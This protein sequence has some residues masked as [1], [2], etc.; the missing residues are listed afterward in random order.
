MDNQTNYPAQPPAASE[1]LRRVLE[2]R[3]RLEGARARTAPTPR[4]TQR[5]LDA[6]HGTRSLAARPRSG[7]EQP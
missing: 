4:D 6:L 5:M 1:A 2:H 3:T 7:P